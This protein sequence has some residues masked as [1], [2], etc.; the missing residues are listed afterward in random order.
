MKRILKSTV[1][2]L[3]ISTV[4]GLTAMATE[5]V[6]TVSFSGETEKFTF[7][8]VDTYFDSEGKEIPDLFTELKGVMP[9]DT[10]AQS[11]SVKTTGMKD[12]DEVRIYLQSKTTDPVYLDIMKQIEMTVKNGS[13]NITAKMSDT[14]LLGTYEADSTAD[15]TVEVDIPIT[16]GNEVKNLTAKTDWIFIAEVIEDV[17]PPKTGDDHSMIPYIVL[18]AMSATLGSWIVKKKFV[19]I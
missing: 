15:I 8:N 9:G 1:A 19:T 10:I 4:F 2:I 17:K 6:P 5:T 12:S 14:V 7:A 18:I 3:A 11:I 16:L 13:E